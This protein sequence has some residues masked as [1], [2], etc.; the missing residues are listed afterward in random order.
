MQCKEFNSLLEHQGRSPLS[1]AAQ[2]HLATCPACQDLLADFAS[3]I[4]MA[5]KLPAEVD[6]PRRVWISLR[7]QLETEGLINEATAV[8]TEPSVHW[9]GG[10]RAWFTPRVLATAG[11]G[12][13]LAIA[14]VLQFH[15]PQ[16]RAIPQE[17]AQ[18]A[19][20]QQQS[21]P[22]TEKAENGQA[23][24]TLV[25][26]PRAMSAVPGAQ[27]AAAGK[28]RQPRALQAQPLPQTGGGT[29][30]PSQNIQIAD[31]VGGIGKDGH[32]MSNPEL[33]DA[34]RTNLQT[35]NEF[36]AECEAHLKKY[37]ND[38]LAREYLESARQQQQELIGAILDSGRSEQ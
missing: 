17:T 16:S 19:M 9:L 37:P 20:Q 32:G 24:A 26:A 8:E 1:D 13:S 6:P 4:A 21:Q 25:P 11:I 30:S 29:S 35:V 7:S 18:V 31:Q 34:L 22:A 15:K 3:I 5:K 10:L 14:A 28:T 27:L 2:D 12:L 23:A 36:I 33:D 38:T